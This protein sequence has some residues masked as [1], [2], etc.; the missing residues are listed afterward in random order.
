MLLTEESKDLVINYCQFECFEMWNSYLQEAYIPGWC[1]TVDEQLASFR[2]RCSFRQF[3][4]SKPGRYGIKLWAICDSECSYVRK[5]I[6]Y[7][8]KDV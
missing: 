6:I 1:M 5:L 8:G 3:I 2:G 7:S 4:P